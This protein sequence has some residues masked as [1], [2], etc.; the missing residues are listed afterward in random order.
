VEVLIDGSRLGGFIN[1][2]TGG[3]VNSPFNSVLVGTVTFSSYSSHTITIRS[4]I[5]G[6][7][8]WDYVQFRPI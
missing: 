3:S 7:L 8:L 5:P 4:L 6:K 2:T 1:L